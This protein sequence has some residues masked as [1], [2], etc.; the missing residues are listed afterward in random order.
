MD[1]KYFKDLYQMPTYK[2]FGGRP[3]LENLFTYVID[4]ENIKKHPFYPF[5]YF[6]KKYY[7]LDKKMHRFVVHKERKFCYSSP[8]D[9][10]I[11]KYY[12]TLLSNKYEAYLL[13]EGLDKNITAFRNRNNTQTN[14][15]LAHIAIEAIKK[16]EDAYIIVSDLKNFF[17]SLEHGYLKKQVIKLLGTNGLPDDYYKVFKYITQCP[18]VNLDTLIALSDNPEQS[19]SSFNRSEQKLDLAKLKRRKK[20]LIERNTK[21][22]GLPQGL[23]IS[24]VLAN[25][26][27]MAFDEKLRDIA[28][29][30]NGMYMRYVDDIFLLLPAATYKDFV[31]EYHNLNNLAKTIPN[32]T[33]SSNKTKCLH[34]QDHAF[35][36]MQKNDTAEQSNALFTEAEEKAVFSYLGFDFDGLHVRLRGST[37]CRYYTKMHR[38]IKT[39]IQCHGITQH[40]HRIN[41]RELYEHYST[42]TQNPDT[43]NFLTYVQRAEDT[44]G[45]DELVNIT[46]KRHM[47]KIKKMLRKVQLED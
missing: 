20:G 32:I 33:L 24:G 3:K 45:K 30:Y 21:K 23:S 29:R 27:M 26:Y 7:R 4:A 8:I 19:R 40:K 41:N 14:I 36:L 16:T 18:A 11:L 17:P 25:V 5:I 1:F 10:C 2:H 28:H 38:K 9:S 43:R 39:I 34:Y 37:I 35:H 46:R 13:K 15:K 12:S 47:G 44:F 42:H 22:I 31:R 6:I